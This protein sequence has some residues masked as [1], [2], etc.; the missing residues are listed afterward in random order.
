M[1]EVGAT[2]REYNVGSHAVLDGHYALR[3][4]VG[5]ALTTTDDVAQTW[6]L[7]RK[8][9]TELAREATHT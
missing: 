5:G 7:I 8:V 1:T 3:L 4:A 6:Q 9:G 2:L